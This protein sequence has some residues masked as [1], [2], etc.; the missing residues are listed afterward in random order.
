[1]GRFVPVHSP[2]VSMLKVAGP[3]P[4]QRLF[5]ELATER[6]CYHLAPQIWVDITSYV[7]IEVTAPPNSHLLSKIRGTAWGQHLQF[8]KVFF[9]YSLL[10]MLLSR[11]L[12]RVKVTTRFKRISI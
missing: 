1:M 5:V 2:P 8:E 9:S 12:L 6:D 10:C 3:R 4:D 11:C 7:H